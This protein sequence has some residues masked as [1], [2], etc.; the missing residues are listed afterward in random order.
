MVLRALLSGQL[1]GSM[2]DDRLEICA[3]IYHM[4]FVNILRCLLFLSVS[5]SKSPCP[6]LTMS[7]FKCPQILQ[8]C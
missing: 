8:F 1:L 6:L 5:D 2:S 7:F 4:I 3:L